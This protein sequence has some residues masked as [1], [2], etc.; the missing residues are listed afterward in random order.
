MLSRRH[1]LQGA[2]A[3]SAA[4][5]TPETVHAL[6]ARD[7]AADWGLAT[8]DLEGDLPRAAMRRVRGRA[9][10]GINLDR[11]ISDCYHLISDVRQS[12][13]IGGR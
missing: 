6:A 7:L 12:T 10:A 3:L 5:L 9:P 4:V 8:R 11:H 1:L 2:A 13:R